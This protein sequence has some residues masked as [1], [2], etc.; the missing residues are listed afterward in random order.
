MDRYVHL[1]ICTYVNNISNIKTSGGQRGTIK[2]DKNILAKLIF[3]LQII[4]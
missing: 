2:V 4:M 1:N 3:T